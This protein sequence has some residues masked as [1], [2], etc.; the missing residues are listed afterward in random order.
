MHELRGSVRYRFRFDEED[1]DVL[2]EGDLQKLTRLLS[3]TLALSY[4]RG[5]FSRTN[6]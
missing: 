4:E 3:L 6:A 2:L 5:S 1:V